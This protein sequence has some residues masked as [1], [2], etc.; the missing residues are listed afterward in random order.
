MNY[1]D[2]GQGLNL[3]LLK[4]KG[5]QNG[6]FDPTGN[7]ENAKVAELIFQSGLSTASQVSDIS[8]RGVGMDAVR[9]YL[10]TNGGAI[11]LEFTG[12]END[13]GCIPFAFKIILPS[14]FCV[15]A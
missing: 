14:S 13:K 5:V 15:E 6:L 8:G 10:T 4:D 12:V 1:R 11:D 9:N 2:D 7:I 3:P